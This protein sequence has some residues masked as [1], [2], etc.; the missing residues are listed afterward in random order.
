MDYPSGAMKYVAVYTGDNRID[1][2]GTTELEGNGGNC[3][4]Q[5]IKML[6][7]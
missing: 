1:T 4:L 5:L 3:L 2:K 6:S 7:G